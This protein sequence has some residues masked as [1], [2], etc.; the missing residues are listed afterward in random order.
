MKSILIQVK[1][2]VQGV[3]FRPF[4]FTVAQKNNLFGWVNNDDQGVNIALEG[5]DLEVENFVTE[6]KNS[7][8][9][10]SQIDSIEIKEKS[11]E[12]FANF[13][14]KK[15]KLLLVNLQL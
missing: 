12:N 3:G 10:L 2:I 4:V 6:L 11:F 9:P 15:V 7:P 8:P 14:I 5:K 13:D 1:G